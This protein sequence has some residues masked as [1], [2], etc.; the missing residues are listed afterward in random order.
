MT[1]THAWVLLLLAVPLLLGWAIITRGHGAVAPVD[2]TTPRVRR[3]RALAALLGVF[4]CWPLLAL[5]AVIVMLAG[6]QI[7]KQP[8]RER[9][10]TNIQ[11]CMDVSGSMSG[12]NYEIASQA[13]ED[14][15]RAREGDAFG[16]TLF[17]V[18]QI[19]WL[20]LTKDLQAIRNAL[21]FANPDYQPS[22]MGGTAIAAAL[23]FCMENMLIETQE[24]DRIIILVS[25]GVS[26][27]L[28]PGDEA[29]LADELRAAGITVYHIHVDESD[30][31]DS[32][33]EVAQLTGGD[34]FRAADAQSLKTVFSHIDRMRPAKF[35]SV[36][37][38]PMDHFAPFAVAALA[39]LAL[40]VMGLM[41]V[42][43]TPW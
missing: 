34:A 7:M 33:A 13:I 22:H 40:H 16:L 38:V 29:D 9:Q 4:E 25:D 27:D 39:L 8:R 1:F 11:I 32:V 41:G 12:R 28:Q 2:H 36:G 43:Y 42:R 24:G 15:T 3:A 30:I 20:P 21:P 10:L 31:P 37:A 6:P 35:T 14:F 17:G 23:R 18:A 19:R 26:F 5:A